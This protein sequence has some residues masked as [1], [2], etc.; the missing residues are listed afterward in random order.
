MDPN[1]L[2]LMETFSHRDK[3][4]ES[5]RKLFQQNGWVDIDSVEIYTHQGT[6][7]VINGNHRVIAARQA[8]LDYVSVV[9]IT[10][11]QL[12]S[13]GYTTDRLALDCIY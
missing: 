10:E 1:S 9:E 13:Y 11:S 5:L 2:A 3:T 6:S 4:V 12:R 8:Q 7:Y